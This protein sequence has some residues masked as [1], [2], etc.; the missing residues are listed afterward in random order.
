MSVSTMAHL[1]PSLPPL[2][3]L[4]THSRLLHR[5]A[6]LHASS[7]EPSLGR[8]KRSKKPTASVIGVHKKPIILEQPDAF[9]PPSHPAKLRNKRPRMVYGRDLTEEDHEVMEG[10]TYPY[11]MPGKNTVMYRF[12]HAKWLHAFLSIVCSFRPPCHC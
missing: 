2:S 11:S 7:D 10:K 9:R 5:T 1:R 6:I 12:M 8:G 4:L 3:R